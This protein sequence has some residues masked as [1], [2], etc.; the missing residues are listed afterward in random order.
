[1]GGAGSWVLL[2]R[3]QVGGRG[4]GRIGRQSAR[5]DEEGFAVGAE[6]RGLSGDVAGWARVWRLR[7]VRRLR[8][9]WGASGFVWFGV[10]LP[11]GVCRELVSVGPPEWVRSVTR[12]GGV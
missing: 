11:N 8:L 7:R 2:G 6:A 1:M 3:V 12:G 9:A 10:G 4:L 5:G